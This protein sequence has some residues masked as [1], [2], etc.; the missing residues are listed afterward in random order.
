MS[1]RFYNGYFDRFNRLNADMDYFTA[2]KKRLAIDIRC[3]SEG[4]S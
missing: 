1:Y 3:T 2:L 4:P